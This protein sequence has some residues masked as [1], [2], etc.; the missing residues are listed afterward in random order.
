[1][2]PK[3]E[4]FSQGEEVVTG[5][6][7]DTNAAWLSTQL[8]EMGFKVS[9]HTAVGDKLEDLISLLQEIASR[10]DCCICTG[11]LGP[12]TDDLTREAVATAFDAPLEFDEIALKNISE[13][14]T[15]RDRAMPEVNRKQAYFPK[16]AKRIDNDW[17]T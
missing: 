9:R 8:V 11:G 13:Y 5:Q 4:I 15:Q 1:M 16:N 3:V 12:T 2:N 6:V 17:G 7:A 14:F 10:A